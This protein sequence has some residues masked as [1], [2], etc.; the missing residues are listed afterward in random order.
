MTVILYIKNYI[1]IFL[2]FIL[3]IYFTYLFFF[4]KKTCLQLIQ[5]EQANEVIFN[6]N[7]IKLMNKI[8]TEW[9][10]NSYFVPGPGSYNPKIIPKKYGP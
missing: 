8:G 7:L 9:K 10:N 6:L 5:Q 1:N 4:K 2:F 3:F